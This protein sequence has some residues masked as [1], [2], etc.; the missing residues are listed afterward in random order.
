MFPLVYVIT[1]IV[2]SAFV[3]GGIVVF[4]PNKVPNRI[5]GKIALFIGIIVALHILFVT[6]MFIVYLFWIRAVTPP[7]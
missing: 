1:V 2:T 4:L 6:A 7:S 3:Y 5:F